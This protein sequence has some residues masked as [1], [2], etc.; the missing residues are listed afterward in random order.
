[1]KLLEYKIKIRTR[2]YQSNLE[3]KVQ[4]RFLLL[5]QIFL[6]IYD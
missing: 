3:K 4:H 2:E 5:E 6:N 1:M